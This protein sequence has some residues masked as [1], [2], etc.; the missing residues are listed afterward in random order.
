MHLKISSVWE[1][2]CSFVP[3]FGTAL[4]FSKQI[5]NILTTFLFGFYIWT[6]MYLF[7]LF[8]FSFIY[9]KKNQFELLK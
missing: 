1:K 6:T 3:I 4:M 8:E 5:Y 9:I 7:F 2:Y